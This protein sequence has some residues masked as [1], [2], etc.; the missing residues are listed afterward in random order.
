ME[1]NFLS[2][3]SGNKNSANHESSRGFSRSLNEMRTKHVAT[4]G[5]R[6]Q[7]GFSKTEAPTSGSVPKTRVGP[8]ATRPALNAEV[9]TDPERCFLR[10]VGPPTPSENCICRLNDSFSFSKW[11]VYGSNGRLFR[12]TAPRTTTTTAPILTP[13]RAGSEKKSEMC[14]EARLLICFPL[15]QSALVNSCL[16]CSRLRGPNFRRSRGT[17][18][19]RD[20]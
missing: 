12:F 14:L 6:R 17:E 15:C 20:T 19:S 7:R 3:L 16:N 13:T 11:A 10:F 1:E 8:G 4:R 9:L 5:V 18:T 2:A